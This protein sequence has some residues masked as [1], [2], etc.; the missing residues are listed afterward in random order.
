M[1][2]RV[3]WANSLD[4]KCARSGASTFA[5]AENAGDFYSE[6]GQNTSTGAA[7][8]P[9][10][11]AK[12]RQCLSFN[13]VPTPLPATREFPAQPTRLRRAAGRVPLWGARRWR[14]SIG[15]Q[16]PGSSAHPPHRPPHSPIPTLRP[17]RSMV[18][19]IALLN[20][21]QQHTGSRLAFCPHPF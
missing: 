17:A 14:N 1:V 12:P 20:S 3:C 9:L 7:F 10:M 6:T 4:E 11:A 2:T 19:E 18:R 13:F 16:L 5:G 15:A 21:T 8:R